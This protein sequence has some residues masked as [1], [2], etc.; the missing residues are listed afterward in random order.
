M[1][2]GLSG[3]DVYDPGRLAWVLS[4]FGCADYID[5]LRGSHG[6]SIY[7]DRRLQRWLDGQFA[8]HGG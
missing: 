4:S 8:R 2:A 6:T 3:S 1:Y 7:N 5:E